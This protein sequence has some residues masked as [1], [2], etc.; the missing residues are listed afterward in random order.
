LTLK[1]IIL[2]APFY[3]GVIKILC[4]IDQSEVSYKEDDFSFSLFK[5]LKK[6]YTL[7]EERIGISMVYDLYY[8]LSRVK[9]VRI[10]YSPILSY[11]SIKRYIQNKYNIL[12]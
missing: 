9:G 1:S 6:F 7:E 11:E 8:A 2:S 5:M 10:E 12:L 3:Y 4:G